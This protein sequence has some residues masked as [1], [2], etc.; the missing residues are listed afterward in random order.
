MPG[1]F[2]LS[3]IRL[4]IQKDLN[5]S[6]DDEIEIGH[7]VSTLEIQDGALGTVTWCL[8]NAQRFNNGKPEFETSGAARAWSATA[9][10]PPAITL[11]QAARK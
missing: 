2:H 3:L 1:V 6:S 11:Y 7:A 10:V 9:G 8:F 4:E 5:L